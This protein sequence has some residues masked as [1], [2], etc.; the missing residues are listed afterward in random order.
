M[1]TSST[2]LKE[3][4]AAPVLL[5]D[6]ISPIP[7]PKPSS[8]PSPAKKRKLDPEADGTEPEQVFDYVTDVMKQYGKGAA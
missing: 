7:F 1:P 4:K 2:P 3:D 5:K 6:Y 8:R